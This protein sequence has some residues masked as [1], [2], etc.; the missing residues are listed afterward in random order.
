MFLGEEGVSSLVI[1]NFASIASV[2]NKDGV[3][4]GMGYGYGESG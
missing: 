4:G 2:K 1:N 3:R